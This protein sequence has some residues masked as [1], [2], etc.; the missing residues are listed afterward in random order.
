MKQRYLGLPYRFAFVVHH[1]AG[2][3]S[4][5]RKRKDDVFGIE[6]QAHS[7]SSRVIVVLSKALPV[8]AAG[9]GSEVVFARSN[10]I[11]S[12]PSIGARDT[13]YGSTALRCVVLLDGEDGYRN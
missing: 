1:T 12:K 11:E 2:Y 7:N 4:G 3:R 10:L 5:T 8:E 9:F 6:S 13:N